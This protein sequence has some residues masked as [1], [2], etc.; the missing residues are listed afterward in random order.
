MTWTCGSP[1][2]RA[3]WTLDPT[4]TFLNHGSFGATPRPVL[5]AQARW[6]AEMEREPV[7]FLARRLGGLGEAVRARL[8]AYL[9][10]DPRGLVPVP[11]A[12]TGINAVFRS[13]DWKPGDELLLA[14]QSYN[15]V[16]QA[17]RFLADRHG[18][19]VVEARI[20]FPLRD[21]GEVV[22][23]YA[24]ALTDRTRLLVVDHI[25][26]PTALILPIARVI[27]LARERGVPVLV[28]GA[29]GPGMLPLALDAIG[30]D[31][32][33]G[34][35]H[36]WLCAPK[37]AA[38]LHLGPA[39]R[40]RVHPLAISHGYGLGLLAEF[41]WAGTSD[42]TAWLAVPD[43]I[44]FFEALGPARVRNEVHALVRDGRRLVADALGVDL[45]HPDD[46]TL[47]GSMAAIPFPLEG[48][49]DAARLQGLT[50]RLY[51]EKRIEVPFTGYDGRAFVRISA[52]VYNAPEDYARLADA[53]KGWRG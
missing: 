1:E 21:A 50:A 27:A 34:N 42:P 5:E 46:P 6:R 29:H 13:L 52:Q 17:A 37:G 43:A 48:P 11:N 36:K 32:Y 4:V 40:D 23:A 12:T 25:V 44:D 53:L 47:Y 9:G 10:A 28:D 49:A 33:V 14:D 3:H 18:V 7:A 38:V 45:P 30:A 8:A 51:D 2:L 16:R 41:D 31:A 19:R 39:L 20:P 22:D 24:A 35:L 15:A 26:S